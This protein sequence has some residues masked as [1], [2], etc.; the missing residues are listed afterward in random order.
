MRK[1]FDFS[2]TVH[3]LQMD[4]LILIVWA[5]INFSEPKTLWDFSCHS[6]LLRYIVTVLYATN[7]YVWPWCWAFATCVIIRLEH[8]VFFTY[9]QVC[10]SLST[11]TRTMKL[12]TDCN[13][14]W[15]RYHSTEVIKDITISFQTVMNLY[16]YTYK[17]VW[18]CL[19][20]V[21]IIIISLQI[22]HACA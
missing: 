4:S 8:P 11:R 14:L 12:S 18:H 9:L 3:W 16:K 13:F 1:Y 17:L 6:M 20:I 7:S 21:R 22:W 2:N 19:S 15:H 10:I 5:S